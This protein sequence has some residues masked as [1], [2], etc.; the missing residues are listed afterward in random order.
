MKPTARA[1]LAAG[2]FSRF[3]KPDFGFALHAHGGFAYDTVLYNI[4]AGSSTADGLEIRFR[5]R[6][7]HGAVPHATIDPVMMAA[8]FV[9]DVQS[10]VSREKDPTEFGVVSFGTIQ[11]GSAA[12]V[13]PD[14]VVLTGTIRTYKPEVRVKLIEG[15]ERTAKAVAAMSNAPEPE[16]RITVGLKAVINDPAVVATAEKV[17]KTAFGDKFRPIPPVM[18]SEDYSEFIN[19]G[20]PSM[21]FR[22][23]VYEP[24]R[25]AAAR[26]GDGQPLPG[27]HS[28][29][30][31]PVPKPTIQTGVVA[32]TLAVLSVF[33]QRAKK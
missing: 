18:P 4:G 16:I 23:G 8:R 19:A 24:E 27:N 2:V 30:F 12:N 17:L 21:F 20:V 15:I 29:L 22:I 9:V 1:M 14:D 25:V 10:V 5:G 33:D 7:G 31:A 26:E 32:M 6:G 11:G 3:P 28:P 13:I